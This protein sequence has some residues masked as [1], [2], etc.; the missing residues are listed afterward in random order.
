MAQWSASR[1]KSPWN[2]ISSAPPEKNLELQV[3]DGFGVY[4]LKFPCRLTAAGCI[5]AQT[6]KELTLQPVGWRIYPR[7]RT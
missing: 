4:A 5:N 7:S 6:Q 2:P 1:S 3:G